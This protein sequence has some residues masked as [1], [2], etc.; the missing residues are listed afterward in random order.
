MQIGTTYLLTALAAV[1]WGAS[2]NLSKHVLVD[3]SALTAGAARFDI[4][5]LAMLAI[6]TIKGQ[7]VP[8]IR[9]GRSYATLG[10]VGIAGFNV[11]FF[12][13]TQTTSAVNA[14]LIMA[15][16]PLTTALL[17]FMVGG[18]RPGL[19]QLI[20]FPIGAAGVSVVVLG[21]GAHFRIAEGDV[22]MLA[23]N[24]CWAF[25]NV[26]AGRLL[27]REVGALANTTGLMVAGA[28]ALSLTAVVAGAHVAVPGADALG[29]L[30]LM[31]LGGTVLAYLF[32]NAGIARLG[33]SRTA[34]FLNLVP[35]SSMVISAFEGRPPT[36][37][38]LTGGAIVI[39]AVSLA[40]LGPAARG[41][42]TARPSVP[43]APLA[44]RPK[45]PC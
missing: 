25:Y 18:H 35:V 8:L 21:G 4:A 22:L 12:Y 37:E 34:L 9:H 44:A 29:S 30:L 23:G 11:L 17:A 3:L 31:S 33:A 28:V 32:W 2:F 13:G 16:N 27:P 41:P 26:M 36:W 15:L 43:A 6:C 20:A 40:M 24:L 7:H 19:R 14:A 42:A 39:A 1:M 38:Q 10:L 45:A 5:A